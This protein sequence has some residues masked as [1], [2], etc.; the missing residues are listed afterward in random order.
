VR[1]IYTDLAAGWL[2]VCGEHDLAL[3]HGMTVSAIR[4]IKSAT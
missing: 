2:P 4:R 1:D 3:S